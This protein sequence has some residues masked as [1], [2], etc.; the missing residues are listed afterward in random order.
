MGSQGGSEQAY[1]VGWAPLIRMIPARYKIS[2]S[3]AQAGQHRLDM[4][5]NEELI[6]YVQHIELL[7]I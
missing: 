3:L 6:S 2:S 5:M 7:S 4:P 1:M